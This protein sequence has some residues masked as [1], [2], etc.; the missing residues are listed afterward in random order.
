MNIKLLFEEIQEFEY[1]L[2][3]PGD[4]RSV[5]DRVQYFIKETPVLNQEY[6][7][8]ANYYKDLY[9]DNSFNKLIIDNSNLFKKVYELIN[10][11]ELIKLKR[12]NA[13][14]EAKKL[15]DAILTAIDEEILPKDTINLF[16]KIEQVIVLNDKNKIL[17]IFNNLEKELGKYIDINSIDDPV[18]E[19]LGLLD[20]ELKNWESVE[21]LKYILK[22][23]HETSY[24]QD[25]DFY[26]VKNSL[27]TYL[28]AIDNS[29]FSIE[30]P[31]RIVYTQKDTT[32]LIKTSLPDSVITDVNHFNHLKN[33]I[34]DNLT[35]IEDL[36]IKKASYL[37]VDEFVNI[38]T[39]ENIK[40]VLNKLKQYLMRTQ[41]QVKNDNKN[42][43]LNK[44]THDLNE[45]ELEIAK[46]VTDGLSN[47]SI[48]KRLC[49]AQG[50][51]RNNLTIIYSKLGIRKNYR[52][53]LKE[54][55]KNINQMT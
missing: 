14:P 42:L 5:F 8:R 25:V 2:S 55:Y 28:F 30:E 33:K 1:E 49:K 50:T 44:N 40:V 18:A 47:S 4:K 43:I 12:A 35:I 51:I 6:Q 48:A 31:K 10:F 26:D 27:G 7:K 11:D 13:T 37:R 46:L 39:I 34:D 9:S 45:S 19:A 38:R 23:I 54:F 52:N 36:L 20:A 32:F 22:Y 3:T 29:L 15:K 21:Y 41:K 16:S 17:N 24:L 53:K